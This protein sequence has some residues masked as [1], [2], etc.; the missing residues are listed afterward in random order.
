MTTRNNLERALD[1][2]ERGALV[3]TSNTR[4]ARALKREFADRKRAAGFEVWES[5]DILP[6]SAWLKR[7][8]QEQLFQAPGQFTALLD[9]A[10]ER[11]VW[12]RI[13][14]RDRGG[15]SVA[16]LAEE[17]ARAWRLLHAF[18]VPRT[19]GE[20]ARKK[21]T[22]A[23]FRWAETYSADC[24]KNGWL[25]E[26]QLTDVV[27]ETAIRT[28]AG[29]NVVLWGFDRFTPQQ[30]ELVDALA[31]SDVR[32][33]SIETDAAVAEA[34]RISLDDSQAELRAAAQWAREILEQVPESRIGIVVPNLADLRGTVERTLLEILHPDAL[35]IESSG[36][37]RAFEISL[38]RSLSTAP[39]VGAALALLEI[40]AGTVSLEKASR[41]LRS[42]FI[43]AE[44]ELGP[45]CLLDAEIRSKGVSE[46]SLDALRS[47]AAAKSGLPKFAGNLRRFRDAVGKFAKR[48][49]PSRWSR[50][51]MGLLR[52]AGWPGS[53]S[54]TSAEHQARQAFADLLGKFARFD[55]VLEPLDFATMFRRLR[56]LA[57]ETLF[58]PENLGAPVQVVG[59]LEAAGSR[60]DYLWVM[61]LHAEAWP[62]SP[63]PSP[64]LPLQSQRARRVTGSSSEERLEYATQVMNRILRSSPEV[65]FSSPL[66]Q[67]DQ[68]L[69]ASPLIEAYPVIQ[70]ESVVE[71]ESVIATERLFAARQAETSTDEI[72]PA[73]T[74]AHSKGGTR[75]FLLQAACPFRAFT[76]LR[77]NAKELEMPTPGID[78]RLR[79]KLLH[80]SLNFI[81]AELQT[82]SELKGKSQ[83]ELEQLVR[84]S[85]E[86]AV[87]ES[88][89]ATYTGWE[90]QVAEIERGRLAGLILELLKLETQRSNF[91]I[92]ELE[93]KKEVAFGG[94]A[95]DVKVDRVDLLEDGSLVLLDYKSGEPKVKSWEGDRPD[96]PQLPIYATQ[97]KDRL[98]AVA[99]VQ[100]AKGEIKFKGYAKR[101]QLLPDT[102]AFA[103]LSD[104]KR[105]SPTWDDMLAGWE[106][107]LKRLGSDYR[108]GRA[109]VDPKQKATCERCH[110]SMVCRI[111]EAPPAGEEDLIDE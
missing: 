18:R 78:R 31:A 100:V 23:F 32:C 35:T 44:D 83:A 67:G 68:E 25:D 47:F 11:L 103:T 39:V 30:Q 60:F 72:G 93:R 91:S 110:L 95:M 19:R 9:D 48:Q 41:L 40:A 2:A 45:R 108:D 27:R 80:Q 70:R 14:G 98:A 53:R 62:P 28:C 76:E 79:G 57:D 26:A 64:F 37:R 63:N 66:R 43:G 61:G 24:M 6:W 65:I 69:S 29:R 7:L 88:D 8:W 38:G 71:T 33:D 73:L 104:S 92:A 59:I 10:Q 101:D 20:Y 54:E 55:L 94:V 85:V 90:R 105:P 4:A 82:Q 87:N 111:D 36:R 84:S 75:I 16:S 97:L 74:D 89:A 51:I 107:V 5:P 81:W 56:I 46:M 86:R 22:S 12:E 58:Q 52:A 3:L 77:L 34:Q 17:A 21:D 50:E 102:D 99:F 109:A 13:I 96:E 1:A 49:P 15:L 42:G 106:R